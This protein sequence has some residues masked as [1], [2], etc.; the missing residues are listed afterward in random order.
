MVVL[1]IEKVQSLTPTPKLFIETTVKA[2]NSVVTAPIMNAPGMIAGLIL[3]MNSLLKERAA[4]NRL[5]LIDDSRCPTALKITQLMINTT[6]NTL[7]S[8][9]FISVLCF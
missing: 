3:F 7:K 6:V 1:R 9:T 8:I 4:A 5:E 2:A